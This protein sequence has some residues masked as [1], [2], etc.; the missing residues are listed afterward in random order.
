V[1]RDAIIQSQ[2]GLQIGI[3]TSELD[4]TYPGYGRMLRTIYQEI[5]DSRS[6]QAYRGFYELKAKKSSFYHESILLPLGADD[7]VVDHI[8][9]VGVYAMDPDKPLT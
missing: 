9:V 3:T 6:P 2:A 4:E 8:L 1:L 5:C 7:G